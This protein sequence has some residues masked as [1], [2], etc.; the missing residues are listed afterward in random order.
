V[1]T[2]I[3]Q[4]VWMTYQFYADLITKK[5]IT[6]ANENRHSISMSFLWRENVFD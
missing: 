5:N 6:K 4:P 3:Q 2:Q 1:Y